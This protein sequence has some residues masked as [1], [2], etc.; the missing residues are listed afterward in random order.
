MRDNLMLVQ[1]SMLKLFEETYMKMKI[2]TLCLMINAL[3]GHVPCCDAEEQQRNSKGSE[4]GYLPLDTVASDRNV[5]PRAVAQRP[6]ETRD[7]HELF[8]GAHQ[9]HVPHAPTGTIALSARARQALRVFQDDVQQR[10]AFINALTA[11]KSLRYADAVNEVRMEISNLRRRRSA[12]EAEINAIQVYQ[13]QMDEKSQELRTLQANHQICEGY[14]RSIDVALMQ[15]PSIRAVVVRQ[16]AEGQEVEKLAREI[17]SVK[18]NAGYSDRDRSALIATLLTYLADVLTDL[19]ARPQ[20][21]EIRGH[22]QALQS[23]LA[24]KQR[25][26]SGIKSLQKELQ[27]AERHACSDDARRVRLAKLQGRVGLYGQKIHNLENEIQELC[28][29]WDEGVANIG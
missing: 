1:V 28:E 8:L 14:L 24:N 9:P 27:D 16:D 20:D 13:R 3:A 25:C 19:F 21:S 23:V 7:G 11:E 15:H 6:D 5:T 29:N 10:E 18:S 26:A 2:V 17:Q 12:D 22:I 4:S